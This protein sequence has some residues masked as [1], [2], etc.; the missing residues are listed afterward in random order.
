MADRDTILVTGATGQVGRSLV[1]QLRQAG[2]SVRAL[3]REP[4]SARLPDGVAA[5]RGDLSRPDTVTAA[6]LD[7]VAAV[8]LLWPFPSADGAAEVVDRMA[9]GTDRIVFLSSMGAEPDQ[10]GT[11]FHREIEALVR[12]SG[13][14]WVFLRAGGFG[15]NTLIWASQIRSGAASVR[16]P[17]AQAARSLIHERDIAAVAT[18]ALAGSVPAP[19]TLVLTGPEAVTQED[20]VRL[21][22]EAIGRPLRYE[23]ISPEAALEQ[24]QAGG[25]PR[26]FAEHALGYWASLVEHPEPVTHTVADVTGTEARPFRQWALDHAD[27]FR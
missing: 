26:E 2:A 13:M 1:E 16:W 24:M 12:Q 19:A 5:V 23:E 6:T 11:P 27:D 17:Y 25:W 14:D 21:I 4:G 3:V 7:G 22:G 18:A 9:S 15:G 8:F 10:A 20:Q